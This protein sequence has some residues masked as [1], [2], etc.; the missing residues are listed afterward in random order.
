MFHIGPAAFWLTF[1]ASSQMEHLAKAVQV[2]AE[3]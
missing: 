3:A 2:A 1:Q